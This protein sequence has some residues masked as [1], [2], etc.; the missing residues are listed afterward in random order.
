MNISKTIKTLLFG[1]LGVGALTLGGLAIAGPGGHGPHRGGPGGPG[2]PVEHAMMRAI[3]DL[4]LTEDQ[5]AIL[6]DIREQARENHESLREQH[7]QTYETMK[8]ELLSDAPD[9]A[10]LHSLVDQQHAEMQQRMHDRLDTLLEIQAVLT[11][12]QRDIVAGELE[13][14]E[15]RMKDRR[16]RFENGEHRTRRSRRSK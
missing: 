3:H 2:G 6:Q 12:A 4:D 15:S 1:A 10:L 7:R 11:P 13:E 14:M 5:R 9:A 8:A 16:E